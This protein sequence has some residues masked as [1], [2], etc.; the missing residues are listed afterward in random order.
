M[1]DGG[2]ATTTDSASEAATG[3]ARPDTVPADGSAEAT[4]GPG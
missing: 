4:D 1:V 3:D 2:D